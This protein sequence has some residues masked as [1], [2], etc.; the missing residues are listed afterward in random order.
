MQVISTKMHGL[1]DDVDRY[2]RMVKSSIP[3][4]NRFFQRKGVDFRKVVPRLRL[5]KLRYFGFRGNAQFVYLAR[6]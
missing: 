6:P 2:D 5:L 1:H 4:P 3:I